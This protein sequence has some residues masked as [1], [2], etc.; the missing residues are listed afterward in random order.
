MRVLMFRNGV[1]DTVIWA[2]E[3]HILEAGDVVARGNWCVVRRK[4]GRVIAHAIDEGT[5]LEVA[6]KAIKLGK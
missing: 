6:G 1:E 2:Y 4:R 3:H 5:R